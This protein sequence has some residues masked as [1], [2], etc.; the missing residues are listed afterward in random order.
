MRKLRQ[1]FKY[2]PYFTGF[3]NRYALFTAQATKLA[4]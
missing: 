3:G 4:G 1:I 2:I